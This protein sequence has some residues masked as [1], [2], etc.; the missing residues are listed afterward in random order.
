MKDPTKSMWEISVL[1]QDLRPKDDRV[2]WILREGIKVF[3]PD[4][5]AKCPNCDS[6]I[7]TNRIWLVDDANG[8]LKG[9]WYKDGTV[10]HQEIIH[11]HVPYNG[12]VCLG[13]SGGAANALFAGVAS[14]RHYHSTEKW[15]SQLGHDCVNAIKARCIG[16][17]DEYYESELIEGN[18]CD[19][20][21]NK[22]LLDI[23]EDCGRCDLSENFTDGRCR[24]CEEGIY[25]CRHCRLSEVSDEGRICDN[26]L[27][28]YEDCGEEIDE[29]SDRYCSDHLYGCRCDHGCDSRLSEADTI[30]EWCLDNC[31]EEEEEEEIHT[32][33]CSCNCSNQ[34]EL[35]G[36]K[37]GSCT[38]KDTLQ[39]GFNGE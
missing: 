20:C 32:C 30:C 28:R 11:P 26:C 16:C 36:Q 14:G 6:W 25:R 35:E 21:V 27:C 9:C 18:G 3:G 31:G 15:F 4:T 10:V 34:V 29:D 38:D 8:F 23:C 12:Q 5:K 7:P 13:Q 33:S 37:C 19:R 2:G 39:L 17:D 24:E 22:G 1:V